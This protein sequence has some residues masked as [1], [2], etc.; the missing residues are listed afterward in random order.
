MPPRRPTLP[1]WPGRRE[2]SRERRAG[3]G[4]VARGRGWSEE[5]PCAWRGSSFIRHGGWVSLAR[6]LSRRGA[7]AGGRQAAQS[8]AADQG[9]REGPGG[10]R[11]GSGLPMHEPPL[12]HAPP[13]ESSRASRC[14]ERAA[15]RTQRPPGRR[16]RPSGDGGAGPR[17]ESRL[18]ASLGA[19]THASVCAA[20]PSAPL[21]SAP[22]VRLLPHLSPASTPPPPSPR[23]PTPPL[24]PPRGS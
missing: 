23:R 13:S 10:R 6:D 21:A 8:S 5:G 3:R 24:P 11:R 16:E 17:S 1:H 2:A 12:R 20:A 18:P 22:A 15:S 19:A 4:R 14:S 7:H 9:A